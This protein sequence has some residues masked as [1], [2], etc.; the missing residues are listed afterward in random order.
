MPNPLSFLAFSVLGIFT[1]GPNNIMSLCIAGKYGFKRSLPFNLGVTAGFL[2]LMSASVA[3]SYALYGALPGIKPVMTAVGA[4]YMLFLAYR[5]LRSGKAGDDPKRDFAGFPAG[6]LLQFVNPKGVL[7]CITVAA[8]YLVPYCGGVLAMAG[9]T[10]L[11]ALLVLAA[12]CMWSAFGAAFQRAIER[13][14]TA[15][16]VVMAVLLA[17]CAVSLFF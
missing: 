7:F 13:H 5:T 3:F 6:V 1:P 12:T 10:L 17:Y 15:F 2:L 14:R 16:N 9:W 8:S 4:A 11:L